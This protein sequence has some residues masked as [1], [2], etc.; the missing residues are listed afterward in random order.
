M[1]EILSQTDDK[2]R[3]KDLQQ[4]LNQLDSFTMNATDVLFFDRVR[5]GADIRDHPPRV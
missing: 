3:D 5:R 4:R 2:M 1:I